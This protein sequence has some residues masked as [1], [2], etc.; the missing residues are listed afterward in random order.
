MQQ[1]FR[2]FKNSYTARMVSQSQ[3]LSEEN[4][5]QHVAYTNKMRLTRLLAGSVASL[6][7][8]KENGIACM[9]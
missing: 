2:N 8:S 9:V 5:M 3:D 4:G 6:S 1:S 7:R